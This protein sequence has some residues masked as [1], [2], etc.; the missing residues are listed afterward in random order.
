MKETNMPLRGTV[1]LPGRAEPQLGSG[2][3]PTSGADRPREWYSRGYL[4]HCDYPGL[5]QTITYRLA[6]S[7]PTEVLAWMERDLLNM[8]PNQANTLR[9]KHLDTQLDAGHGCCIL[10]DPRAAECVVDTWRHFAGER[11]DLIAWVVM[12]NHVHVLIRVYEG[13]ALGKI[14]QSWKSYTGRKIA[15]IERECRAGAR[16]SQGDECRAGALRS[17]DR[18]WMREYWDRFIRDERHFSS[19]VNYIH[20]NPVRVGLIRRAEDWPWSSAMEW[21]SEHGKAAR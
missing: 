19:A 15:Q 20:D 17:Q 1:S 18:V 4:P 9:R 3:D 8:V 14:V 10:R 2:F 7:L 11:Y 6:D 21:A 5:L 16:R 13:M 12:P